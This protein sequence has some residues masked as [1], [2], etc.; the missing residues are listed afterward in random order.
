MWVSRL[1]IN[2]NNIKVQEG[3]PLPREWQI[4]ARL[5]LLKAAYGDE[6]FTFV[7]N[8]NNMNYG[9]KIA[10]LEATIENINERVANI[11]KRRKGK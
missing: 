8:L 9:L 4:P 11:E 7:E 2:A 10:E 3:E 5:R 6:N 1:H